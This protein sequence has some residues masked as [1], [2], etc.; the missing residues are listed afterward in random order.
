MSEEKPRSVA[1]DQRS[2]V[3]KAA[4]QVDFGPSA[5]NP[6]DEER[7]EPDGASEAAEPKTGP[8]GQPVVP[9]SRGSVH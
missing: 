9:P 4:D 5:T 6:E 1:D 7:P 8:D 2:P 3:S